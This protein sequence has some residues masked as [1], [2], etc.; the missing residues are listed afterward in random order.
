MHKILVVTATLGKRATL[1]RTITSVKTIGGESVDHIVIAPESQCSKLS[2]EYKGLTVVSEPN[3]TRGI[4]GVLNHVLKKYA[5]KYEYM[6]FINDDDF[7]LP[8]Y[9]MLLDYVLRD[10][11][12]DVVYGRVKYFDEESKIIGEQTCSPYY[13]GFKNLL[14]RNIVLM[15]QQA[16]VFKSSMFMELDGF[17]EHY[18]LIADTDLWCRAI[19]MNYSF[20]YVDRACAGYTIQHDQLSSDKEAQQMEHLRMLNQ[21][22]NFNQLACIK[23]EIVFR[24]INFRRYL[25]RFLKSGKLVSPSHNSN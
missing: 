14:K 2:Q 19:E 3:D 15:T 23:D 10:D 18:R 11:A 4:F 25:L 5:G 6:T 1:S 20:H 13:K 21:I 9:R 24:L 22:G 17:N 16:M 12:V 7:W 8:N